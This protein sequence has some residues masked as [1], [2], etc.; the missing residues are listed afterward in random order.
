VTSVIPLFLCSRC[1]ISLSMS[2]QSIYRRM[3]GYLAVP[4]ALLASGVVALAFALVG[5]YALNFL[6]GKLFQNQDALG[7][8]ITAFF[9]A[10]PGIGLLAFVFCFSVFINWH[11]ATSWLTPTFAFALGTILVWLWARDFGGVGFVWY[12]P[13]TTAWLISCWFLHRR[14]IPHSKHV[15]QA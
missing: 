6:F 9:L 1:Y 10:A 7:Y 3:P 12:L 13:G 11:H 15:L 8:A 14:S 5:A 2:I 4:L